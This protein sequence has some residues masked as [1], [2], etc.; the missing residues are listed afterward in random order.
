MHRTDVLIIGAGQAG[1]AMSHGLGAHGIEHVVVERGRVAESWRSERWD[2]LTLLTPNWMTRLPGRAGG[3]GDPDGFMGCGAVVDL[4]AGY[5]ATLVAPVLGGTRV[6]AVVPAG[7]GYR[8]ATDRGS[9]RARAVVVATGACGEP[10]VPAFAA[11]LPGDV[12]QVVPGGYRRPSDLPSGGVLVVG[13]SSTGVQLAAEIQESGRQVTLAVGRHSRMVRR[14]R[15]RD[16]FAWMEATGISAQSWTRVADIAAA[17]RQPSMQLSGRGSVDLATLAA[18]G[19][20]VVGRLEGVEGGRLRLG[21]GL[22]SD[23]A[24]SDDRLHR[25]LAR[26]DAH[27]A[28]AGIGAP[29]D[30]AAWRVPLLPLDAA[31]SLDLKAEGIASVIWATGYRRDYGWLQVPVLDGA[32]ELIHHGGITAAPGLYAIGLRFLRRRS[33]NFIDGVGRDAE[34]LAAE[35]AA[36]LGARLAA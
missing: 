13:G 27:V 8:V 2:S 23:C 35:I 24:A 18:A 20:R 15:G 12:V 4:L 16:I 1:L 31:R 28:A 17:R 9:W 26:I 36:H 25:T 11:G 7:D 33:S 3:V 21:D 32:G 19:V 14:Y 34:D 10:R 22:A 5:A 29:A 6:R 30:P